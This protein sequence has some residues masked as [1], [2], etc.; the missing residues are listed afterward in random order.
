MSHINYNKVHQLIKLH[1][2]D[3]AMVMVKDFIAQDPE[4]GGYYHILAY[5]L[6]SKG[7]NRAALR[8]VNTAIQLEPEKA[9]YISQKADFLLGV[10]LNQSLKT[11]D[12]AIAMDP[13]D[14]R[15]HVTRAQALYALG[16]Y[17]KAHASILKAQSLEPS[18]CQILQLK[19]HILI[20]LG[21]VE[22][23]RNALIESLEIDASNSES[24]SL[25]GR[26]DLDRN[27]IQETSSLFK[28]ALQS[29]PNSVRAQIGL[30]ESVY[31]SNSLYN[32]INNYRLKLN[33]I[34]PLTYILSLILLIALCVSFNYGAMNRWF[35]RLDT[36]LFV[37]GFLFLMHLRWLSPVLLLISYRDEQSRRY[38]TA[39]DKKIARSLN[40][41][42]IIS[43]YSFIAGLLLLG[44]Y[45]S[46]LNLFFSTL[47]FK[48]SY[49]SLMIILL[50][51]HYRSKNVV[52]WEWTMIVVFWSMFITV[53]IIIYTTNS[54]FMNIGFI[55]NLIFT[56]AYFTLKDVATKQE[57]S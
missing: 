23:A 35:S 28:S 47:L 9:S 55:L 31:R 37:L 24:L 15:S 43:R 4:F 48:I 56:S 8:A 7:D 22:E 42:F 17:D 13:N 53:D 5:L 26:H 41:L 39:M 3:Q 14:Y 16:K 6:S 21:N 2:E 19:Y 50:L 51:D 46:P 18:R 38:N 32:S 36:P 54:L 10:N 12:Q 30:K 44:L 29:D 11:I 52:P 34:R 25:L 1:R 33:R 40:L 57:S 20:A 45:E 49:A 27:I